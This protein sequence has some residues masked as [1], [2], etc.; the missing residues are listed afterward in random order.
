MMKTPPSSASLQVKRKSVRQIRRHRYPG[1]ANGRGSKAQLWKI[2]PNKHDTM[3]FVKITPPATVIQRKE[4][5]TYLQL[6]DDE[7]I[8]DFLMMDSCYK[9]T[10]KYLL[11]MTFVYFKRA[12]FTIAEY[13]RK[14]FFI[15][16]YL[17]NTMEEEEEESKYEIFPWALGKNWLRMFPRFLQQR[18]GLWTRIQYRAVVSSRCCEKVMAI[19]ASHAAWQ[20]QRFDHHSGAQR[21][22]TDQGPACRPRGPSASRKACSLCNCGSSR[23]RSNVSFSAAM[24]S[25]AKTRDKTC[26]APL[27][28]A[29]SLELTPP[30][31]AMYFSWTAESQSPDGPGSFLRDTSSGKSSCDALMDWMNEM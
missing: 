5:E 28:S 3:C 12:S 22:Y 29:F 30:R 21:R 10:D 31:A 7:V 23:H 4:M 20:R 16:L 27:P 13:T 15:A 6:L 14:N 17:A 8:R 26:N 11:A 19:A 18:D 25:S 1:G 2:Q 9:V 24:S